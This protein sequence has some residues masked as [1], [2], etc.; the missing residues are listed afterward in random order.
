MQLAAELLL[1]GC[2]NSG[3]AD[4]RLAREEHD[5]ALA[6]LGPPPTA[7]EQLHL[8]L[9]PDEGSERHR[10]ERLEPA[11]DSHSAEELG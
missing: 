2:G 3:L 8:L 10:V 9:T 7:Q 5:L 11:L 4:T 6:V 1:Q